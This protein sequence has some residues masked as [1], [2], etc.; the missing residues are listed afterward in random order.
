MHMRPTGYCGV[1]DGCRGSYFRM[2]MPFT[3]TKPKVSIYLNYTL[4]VLHIFVLS[5]VFCSSFV[6]LSA[7]RASENSH[8]NRTPNYK[9]NLFSTTITLS[10]SL[11]HAI[12]FCK[13]FRVGER[14]CEFECL[15]PP[16][17]DNMYQ[18]QLFHIL[19]F[20]CLPIDFLH[21][22]SVANIVYVLI[23]AFFF[24]ISV[25]AEKTWRNLGWHCWCGEIHH[26]NANDGALCSQ[27][28]CNQ[29]IHASFIVT[30][31]TV[32]A[33]L[34]AST[35]LN[36][37]PFV[38]MCGTTQLIGNR[39]TMFLNTVFFFNSLQTRTNR[40]DLLAWIRTL[41]NNSQFNETFTNT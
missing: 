20:S 12:K 4:C 7:L 34:N 28:L 38:C 8:S 39:Q 14:C 30:I 21:S 24:S 13:N 18:V 15:D 33:L 1:F 36:Q 19:P 17:E 6:P 32:L 25:A 31:S 23:R 16:G 3:L 29:Q 9:N 41:A 10:Q 27:H 37:F 5:D 11:L 22:V 2:W 26:H 40:R 35:I